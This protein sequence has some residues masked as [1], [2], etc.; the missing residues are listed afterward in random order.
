LFVEV[1]PEDMTKS[2]TITKW[3]FSCSGVFC[4]FLVP[5]ISRDNGQVFLDLPDLTIVQNPHT[6]SVEN[7]HAHS[8]VNSQHSVNPHAH[9][10]NHENH[11]I[12]EHAR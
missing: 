8:V 3:F 2:I 9:C 12:M 6:H 1:L 10:A 11:Y 4:L 5:L 7:P